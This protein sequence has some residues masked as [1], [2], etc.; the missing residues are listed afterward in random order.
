MLQSLGCALHPA[1]QFVDVELTR[2]HNALPS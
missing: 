2:W 1:F